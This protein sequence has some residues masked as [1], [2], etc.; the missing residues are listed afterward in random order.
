MKT[1]KNGEKIEQNVKTKIFVKKSI[2]SELKQNDSLSTLA[3]S[4]MKTNK[5]RLKLKNFLMEIDK[6]PKGWP[7]IEVEN[8][9]SKFFGR[10]WKYFY[11]IA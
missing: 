4:R 11:K 3:Y 6:N 1:I 8:T 7:I 2:V 5:C 10:F 9:C